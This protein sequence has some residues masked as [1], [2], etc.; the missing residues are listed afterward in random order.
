LEVRDPWTV[1]EL[2]CWRWRARLL[3]E[4]PPGAA[5]PYA[6]QIAGE[7]QRAAQRWSE[8][9]C[10]YETALA[11]AD[12]GEEAALRQALETFEQLGARPMMG[13]VARRLREMG[14]RGIP[15]G[16]RASTRAH[17]GGLTS[18][19]LEIAALIVQGLSNLEIAKRS[20]LSVKTVD[21]HVSSIL[22]KLGVRGRVD[23]AREA[24]RLG[25]V[26]ELAT[27]TRTGK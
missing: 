24:M 23:I 6:L 11:L 12:S 17:P 20:Y 14:V 9:G 1:G 7:W 3:H 25:L 16:P 13:V 10:P 22:A 18:R 8:I 19:E 26:T 4:P 27:A 15:R 21:H 2:A 5:E